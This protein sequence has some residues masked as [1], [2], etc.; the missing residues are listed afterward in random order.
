MFVSLR[1]VLDRLSGPRTRAEELYHLRRQL[2]AQPGPGVASRK[3]EQLA[4][5]LRRLREQLAARFG[6]AEACAHCGQPGATDWPGGDCCSAH[7]QELFSDGELAALRLAG[8]RPGHLNHRVPVTV[9]VHFV[10]LRAARSKPRIDLASASAMHAATCSSSS[11]DV[12][13]DQRTPD[14]RRNSTWH[15]SVS[16]C[17]G[18][19][20]CR[21]PC[22]K[23]CKRV[24]SEKATND[25]S[26]SI[27]GAIV[28]CRQLTAMLNRS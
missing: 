3:E 9:V 19:H 14:Y 28:Y 17:R 8:T 7:T 11:I 23:S 25:Q 15:S 4:L 20:A 6:P 18:R 21:Q 13:M 16:W 2:L 1:Y 22:S 27:D 24:C 12:G 26:V 10:D 5:R